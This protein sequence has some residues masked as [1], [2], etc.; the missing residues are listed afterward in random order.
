MIRATL[1]LCF[2]LL[3]SPLA[4]ETIA[5]VHARAI[6][7]A[8]PPVEDATIIL[9]GGHIQS[10]QA[11]GTV[12]SGS[13]VIDAA[14]R[15]VTPGLVGAATQIGISEVLSADDTT[16]QSVTSG[17]LGPAFDVQYAINS[18]STL[19]PVARTD[20][21]TRAMIFPGG[22][23]TIPFSGM[24]AVV[25][26][27]SSG[28]ILE[29]PRAAMF[30]VIGNGTQSR[31]G[32]SRAAQWALL[33][34]A[35]GEARRLASAPRV[36]IP[37]DQLLGRQDAEALLPVVSGRMKLVIQANRESD[38][39]QAIRLASD[40]R[41]AVVIMGGAEAW[42]AA[43]ELAAA[44]IPVILD[45][46]ADLPQTFDSIGARLD[47]AALLSRAGVTIAFSVSGN[48]IYLSYN[49]G[50][51]MREGAGIA[52]ANGLA[53]AAALAAITAAPAQIWGIE[54]AGT[55]AVGADA[56]VVI[57]DG[58]PLEPSSAPIAVFVDGVQASLA[59]RQSALRDRYAP[60]RA[61]EAL[62]PAYR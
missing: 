36:T 55:L 57:W 49:A 6:P 1:G 15:F 30:S 21:L 5:I 16:D 41:V 58:D 9:A 27:R 39:R 37:R 29:R 44:H 19:L 25:R 33:R 13:K 53:Y 56:D 17:P 24:G 18:N 7:V 51:D 45:P 61:G 28:D 48:G 31:A 2:L 46:Q 12:P 23:T 3:G 20:G 34:N 59:T 60:Q 43:T 54:R 26:L 62:P 32:G 35:L 10:V 11:H 8:G 50:L 4:A 52:V 38:I 47:N 22:G 40:E 14:G 42:R